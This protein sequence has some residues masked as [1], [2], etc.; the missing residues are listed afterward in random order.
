MQ[1]MRKMSR[2]HQ[3]LHFGVLVLLP[4]LL[5]LSS[6]MCLA[7]AYK[8]K[9]SANLLIFCLLLIC[10]VF[11]FGAS[12]FNRG[13][14]IPLL[15]TFGSVVLII[16]LVGISR[17]VESSKVLYTA[18]TQVVGPPYGIQF[19]AWAP[20]IGVSTPVTAVLLV[21]AMGLAI[22]TIL[23]MHRRRSILPVLVLDSMPLALC[24]ILVDT[25]PAIGWCLTYLI[26]ACALLLSQSARKR[27]RKDGDTL[28]LMCLVPC[29]ALVLGLYALLPEANYVRG[30]SSQ[31]VLQQMV[32]VSAKFLPVDMDTFGALDI[33]VPVATVEKLLIG[34]RHDSNATVLQVKATQSGPMYLRG[35]TYCTYTG[36]SWEMLPDSE[37]A[38]LDD[39]NWGLFAP[40]PLTLGNSPTN[41]YLE[42][43]TR[44]SQ[45]VLYTPYYTPSSQGL[46]SPRVDRALENDGRLLEYG[47]NY[48]S[49]DVSFLNNASK[50]EDTGLSYTSYLYMDGVY[51]SI[52]SDTDYI[53]DDTDLA[54]ERA[55]YNSFVLRHYTQLP[56]DTRESLLDLADSWNLLDASPQEV[57][58]RVSQAARYD[59]DTP[60]MPGGSDFVIW[61]LGESD[62]GYCVHY[63]S[64]A[65]A[66][67][68]ALG[69]PA[70]YVT[71]YLI[72][73]QENTWVDVTNHSAH[74]WTEVYY[75]GKGWVPLEA[76]PASGL[77]S[78]MSPDLGNK[79]PTEPVTTEPTHIE[80]PETTH[81]LPPTHPTDDYLIGLDPDVGNVVVGGEIPHSGGEAT[82][83]QFEIPTWFWWAL[84]G[85]GVV[86]LRR[87]ITRKLRQLRLRGSSRKAYL[88]RWNAARILARLLRSPKKLED[89]ALK[90]RFSNHRMSR[91]DWDALKLWELELQVTVAALPTI[92]RFWIK[93]ILVAD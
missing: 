72:S 24:L 77:E 21:W 69:Y 71:G 33:R 74:A 8:L 2:T 91:E 90:A 7:T 46:G 19:P 58:D 81:P 67:L 9:V 34:P 5:S 12:R 84:A 20:T 68:R 51:L 36:S 79:T 18:I 14:V 70:R 45:S 10:G 53:L 55:D 23:A 4:F 17:I 31:V 82:R 50:Y 48:L 15:I 86:I 43:R 89:Q 13:A 38:G 87:F 26:A 44:G 80:P 64:A 54:P 29:L 75:P 35:M 41:Q 16:C 30:G 3:A 63:A 59:L 47:L 76:T 27:S 1:K 88:D 85:L 73:A 65:T 6:V 42:I 56:D 37:Y 28:A 60:R 49:G 92:K 57:A 39:P 62:T 93:W 83:L 40:F 25:P 52:S 22:A 61:F 78:T 32:D 11:S 66:M